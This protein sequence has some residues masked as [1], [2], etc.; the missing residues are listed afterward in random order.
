MPDVRREK[1]RPAKQI[2]IA[3]LV[4]HHG[5]VRVPARFERH[6]AVIDQVKT[7]RRVALPSR[8]ARRRSL[9]DGAAREGN[10]NPFCALMAQSNGSCAARLRVQQKIGEGA[11]DQ[12][13]T[14]T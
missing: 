5:L 2:A 10:E 9:A 14:V 11:T 8:V 12:P 6:F 7:I 1:P 13:K 3:D 4:D